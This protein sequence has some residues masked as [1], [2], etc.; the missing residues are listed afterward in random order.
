MWHRMM[1]S[2]NR[3][4]LD[5]NFLARS[6]RAPEW[7]MWRNV[8]VSGCCIVWHREI[9]IWQLSAIAII[10]ASGTSERRCGESAAREDFARYVSSARLARHENS[11][12]NRARYLWDRT[13]GLVG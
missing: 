7:S 4:S 10:A 2:L 3:C 11:P 8:M 9:A 13:L 6:S 5:P 1:R 12:A